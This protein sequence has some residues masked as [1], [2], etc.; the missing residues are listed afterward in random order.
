M[1][2]PAIIQLGRYG[3]ILNILP[4]CEHLRNT[5]EARPKLVVADQFRDIADAVSYADVK[6]FPGPFPEVAQ[7][8]R[9]AAQNKLG[10]PITSQIY[11]RAFTVKKQCSNFCMESY[12]AAGFLEPFRNGQFDTI[13]IDVRDDKAEAKLVERHMPENGLPF[14]LFNMGGASS[15]FPAHHRDAYKARLRSLLRGKAN[16]LDISL[17]TAGRFTDL[18][19]IYDKAVFLVTG[20]TG[21]LHLAGAHTIP[22]AAFVTD[23]PDT[24]FSAY[25]RGNCVMRAKYSRANEWT[26]YMEQLCLNAV[27]G[28][29]PGPSFLH[30]YQT[31]SPGPDT[32]R[33]NRTAQLT[34]RTMYGL[35]NWKALPVGDSNLPRLFQDSG[36]QLPYMRDVLDI[37]AEHAGPDRL[38][39]WSNTDTCF[40]PDFVQQFGTTTTKMVC[41]RRDFGTFL[42]PLTPA[43]VKTGQY[44]PGADAFIFP[45]EWWTQR[46]T[47]FPDMVMG[48]EGFDCVLANMLLKDGAVETTDLVYHERHGST[49]EANGNRYTLP[50]QKHNL[51]LGA[52]ALRKMG[53]DPAKF[54][55][56]HV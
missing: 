34:W 23:S 53:L 16:L 20:D 32:R 24:W 43:Q 29:R 36:R 48:A 17:L 18:L 30:V 56:K 47:E 2:A 41:R 26:E 6:V 10:T 15:P 46:R 22:Y 37:A 5:G 9:W 40:R 14:V 12:R 44:Y 28:L 35:G 50:S 25:T 45:T 54:G 33:R 21:T 51:K 3:D 42:D 13:N 19:G 55:F 1:Q 11:G 49:W 31:F 4:L 27:G 7:A 39:V 38:I 8:Q 52:A